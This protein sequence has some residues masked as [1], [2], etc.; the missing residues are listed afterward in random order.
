M[1]VPWVRQ[2]KLLSAAPSGLGNMEGKL[3]VVFACR[4]RPCGLRRNKSA[5]ALTHCLP[6][7]DTALECR[8]LCQYDNSLHWPNCKRRP[9]GQDDNLSCYF[10]S[11]GTERIEKTL[12]TLLGNNNHIHHA[13]QKKHPWTSIEIDNYLSFWILILKWYVNTSKPTW[14]APKKRLFYVPTP[15]TGPRCDN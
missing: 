5:V 8:C 15:R 6:S 7:V 9:I 2:D 11:W 3:T 10:T 13:R 12:Y 14:Q 4:L 1:Q